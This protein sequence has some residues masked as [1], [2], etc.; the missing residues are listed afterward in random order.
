MNYEVI[1]YE[2][3]IGKIPFEEWLN[4][5]DVTEVAM[6]ARRIDRFSKGNFGDH[7]PVGFGIF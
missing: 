4:G 5:L 6:I 2:T 7:E 1:T 3:E